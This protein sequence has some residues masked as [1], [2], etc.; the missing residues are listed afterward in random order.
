MPFMTD[1]ARF[2]DKC[3]CAFDDHAETPYC[4][5]GRDRSNM[6]VYCCEAECPI[7]H[8]HKRTIEAIIE[9]LETEAPA[10]P[11]WT[12]VEPGKAQ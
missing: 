12:N 3:P 4:S 1:F 5:I 8:A 2:S 7:W 11:S 6:I 10:C 9:M